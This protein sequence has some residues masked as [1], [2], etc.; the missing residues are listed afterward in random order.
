VRSVEKVLRL[1][2][3]RAHNPAVPG[4]PPPLTADPNRGPLRTLLHAAYDAL[5][6]L[7]L[8]L[9]SPVFL[10]RSLVDPAFRR[11]ARERLTLSLPLPPRDPARRRILVHGVSVGEIKGSAPLVRALS[12][13]DPTAEIVVSSTTATGLEVARQ[14]FPGLRI[15]RFPL[16]L[17]FCVARFLRRTAPELVVLIELEIWPNFLRQCNAAGIPVAVVNGRITAQSYRRYRRFRRALPQFNRISLFCVQLEEYAERF[18]ALGGAPERVLVTGNMKADGL[19]RSASRDRADAVSRLRGLLAARDGRLTIVAGSTHHP[20]ETWFVEACRRAAPGAR[21]VVVPRH[22]PR[23][24]D[25]ARDLASL[26]CPPQLLTALRRGDEAPDPSRPALVD[27]IGELEAIY[28]LADIVFVGGSLIEH[29]G[30]NVL[31]PAA[32]GCAVVYGPHV[33]NFRQEAALLESKGASRR[34]A[35]RDELARA[36]EELSR[37]AERRRRMAEAARSAVE[38]Q[39]GATELTLRALRERCLD[40]ARG[41]APG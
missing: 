27:T 38:L 36:L 18:R 37:D 30:Q 24:A 41:R 2:T 5:W 12:E 23:A 16:D 39:R 13:H 15:V 33:D 7:A 22:P 32:H 28:E 19:F 8:A 9:L 40:A 1:R 29:G 20:E 35:D 25:V 31:E 17:S 11:M 4:V 26:G 21:L 14:I 34:V 6:L 10:A 3:A